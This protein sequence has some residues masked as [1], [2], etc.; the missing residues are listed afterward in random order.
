MPCD[1][2]CLLTIIVA[3]AAAIAGGGGSRADTSQPE[4]AMPSFSFV[5]QPFSNASGDS[6]QEYLAANL[7]SDLTAG[8]SRIQGSLVIARDSAAALARQT[9][10]MADIGHQMGVRFVL[11]GTVLRQ[12][13]HVRASAALLSTT[14]GKQVWAE[15]FERDF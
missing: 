8:L 1:P 9:T 14:S 10:E 7:T 5:V 12:G 4:S 3:L 11:R 2:R 15:D 6:N 13:A